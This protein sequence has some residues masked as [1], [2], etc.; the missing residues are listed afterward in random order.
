MIRIT[1]LLLMAALSPIMSAFAAP[2]VVTKITALP[3]NIVVPGTYI[4]VGNLSFTGPFPVSGQLPPICD[5]GGSAIT[6]NTVAPG[7][8]V[9]D[10]KGFTLT[11]TS[12][13]LWGGVRVSITSNATSTTI[14]NGTITASTGVITGP[15]CNTSSSR[16]LAGIRVENIVFQGG[17]TGVN[18]NQVNNSVVTGCTFNPM[19]NGIIDDFSVTGNSY[20]NNRFQVVSSPDGFQMRALE[21]SVVTPSILKQCQFVQP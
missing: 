19:E 17:I 1:T 15:P 4:F 7:A 11:E 12:Q 9:V 8:V 6:I 3:Y 21:V 2:P 5:A 18:F 16:F 10:L 13:T 14:R 20:S